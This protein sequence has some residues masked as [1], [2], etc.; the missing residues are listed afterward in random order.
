MNTNVHNG[1]RGKQ[2]GESIMDNGIYAEKPPF[3]FV[4][5]RYIHEHSDEVTTT[6]LQECGC[7]PS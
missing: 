5:F 3:S 7:A 1:R 4:F 6:G 2:K